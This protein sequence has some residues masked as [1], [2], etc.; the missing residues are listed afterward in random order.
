MSVSGDKEM[1][2]FQMTQYQRTEAEKA[3]MQP[4]DVDMKVKV[5]LAQ[6]RFVFL[7]LWLSRLMKWLLPFQE[8]AQKAA[9]AA[10]QVLPI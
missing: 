10:Q 1:L 7:N 2:H 6:M 9:A 8:E 5:R 4:I 3:Q